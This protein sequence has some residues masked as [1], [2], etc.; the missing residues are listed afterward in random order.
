[1]ADKE[2][3]KSGK[4]AP[5][6]FKRFVAFCT[7]I[8]RRPK[9]LI[10]LCPSWQDVQLDISEEVGKY[11]EMRHVLEDEI[12]Q[13]IFYAE[14]SGDKLYQP[15][16]NKYLGKLQIGKVTFYADYSYGTEKF[17]VN[18]AYTHRSQIAG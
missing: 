10:Q 17:I 18:L 13:V 15:D 2:I 16:G 5:G 12:K 3:K 14:T 1:M 4:T 11:L 8:F 9:T 6:P 7:G